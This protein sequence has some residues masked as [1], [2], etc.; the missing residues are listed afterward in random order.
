MI[1]E[2]YDKGLDMDLVHTP[3]PPLMAVYNVACGACVRP[4]RGPSRGQRVHW[5]G[6]CFPGQRFDP[7]G[8]LAELGSCLQKGE[9]LWSALTTAHLI[10]GNLKAVR[11]T[12]ETMKFVLTLT[13]FFFWSD[14]YRFLHYFPSIFAPS[15]PPPND[16]TDSRTTMHVTTYTYHPILVACA[17]CKLPDFALEVSSAFSILCSLWHLCCRMRAPPPSPPIAGSFLVC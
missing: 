17:R 6:R 3:L 14:T 5:Q 15:P 4:A 12:I 8:A 10:T 16:V 13:F 9:R 11:D 2:I 7:K 1:K